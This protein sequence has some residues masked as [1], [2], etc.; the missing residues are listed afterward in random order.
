MARANSGL[1]ASQGG[2]SAPQAGSNP[3]SGGGA[4]GSPVPGMP[5][6]TYTGGY[7]K[8]DRWVPTTQNGLPGQVNTADGEF[9]PDPGSSSK[10][11][12]QQQRDQVLAQK[13]AADLAVQNI[14]RAM[15]LSPHVLD[16]QTMGTW[17]PRTAGLIGMLPGTDPQLHAATA[18]YDGILN[19]LPKQ[20]VMALPANGSRG[21]NYQSQ[22]T[23]K[24]LP[25]RDMDPLKRQVVLQNLLTEAKGYQDSFNRILNTSNQA[26]QGQGSQQAQSAPVTKTIGGHTYTQINGK[27]VY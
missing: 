14:Q 21:T 19:S 25:T 9:K 7:K 8:V 26:Q 2:G 22:L 11:L 20:M 5:G 24:Q 13:Q 17:S 23:V 10:V 6:A 4:P 12:T 18:E 27:W 16:G 1:P 15:V 3:A